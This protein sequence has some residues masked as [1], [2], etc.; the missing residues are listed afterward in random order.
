MQARHAAFECLNG[1]AAGDGGSSASSS[2]MFNNRSSGSASSAEDSMRAGSGADASSFRSTSP[3]LHD[4]RPGS[5]QVRLP[6]QHPVHTLHTPSRLVCSRS[7]KILSKAEPTSRPS[8]K[9]CGI[10]MA[11]CKAAEIRWLKK[12]ML[13]ANRVP[14][15]TG[16]RRH[17]GRCQPMIQRSGP[18][19]R[20]AAASPPRSLRYDPFQAVHPAKHPLHL[21]S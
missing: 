20:G 9:P 7:P 3:L 2:D 8:V 1:G 12:Y 4:S 15:R 17:G 6:P 14:P 18:R 13:G 19:R 5:A 16:C 11:N 21:R 10:L